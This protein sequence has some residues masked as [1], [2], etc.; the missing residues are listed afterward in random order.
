[1]DAT[2]WALSQNLYRRHLTPTEEAFALYSVEIK[3][4]KKLKNTGGKERERAYRKL[5]KL[6][7]GLV[8]IIK[9][10]PADAAKQV[11]QLLGPK[12]GVKEVSKFEALFCRLNALVPTYSDGTEHIMIQLLEAICSTPKED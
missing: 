6:K 9:T 1:K 3:S 8:D 2:I 11:K 4:D 5:A 10:L 7:E 12:R